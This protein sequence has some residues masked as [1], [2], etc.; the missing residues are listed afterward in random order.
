M[1]QRAEGDVSSVDTTGLVSCYHKTTHLLR[2]LDKQKIL[3]GVISSRWGAGPAERCA[4]ERGRSAMLVS[5]SLLP[6]PINHLGSLCFVSFSQVLGFIHLCFEI[7][8][9]RPPRRT[10]TCTQTH[11]HPER[12]RSLINTRNK[13]V[14]ACMRIEHCLATHRCPP[15]HI[16]TRRYTRQSLKT[17]ACVQDAC[18]TPHDCDCDCD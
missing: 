17:H 13:H 7:K 11:T 12:K 15:T 14:C 10:R 2:M 1:R 5:W 8:H 3:R 9:T 16:H 6:E 4:S 18:I